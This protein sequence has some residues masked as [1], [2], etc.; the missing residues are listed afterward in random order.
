M[1]WLHYEYDGHPRS[2]MRQVFIQYHCTFVHNLLINLIILI[3]LMLIM[4]EISLR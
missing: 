3:M 2:K 1:G 4:F